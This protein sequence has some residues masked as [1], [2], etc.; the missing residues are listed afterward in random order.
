MLLW[1]G[2]F[3]HDAIDDLVGGNTLGIGFERQDQAVT[4]DIV[5]DR[6][7]V[8]RGDIVAVL[9]PCESS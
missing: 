3:G 1:H 6:L 4:Q 5:S 8:F 2:K 7:Y 9:Q